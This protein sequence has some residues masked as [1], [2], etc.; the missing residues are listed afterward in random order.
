M[1]ISS[2]QLDYDSAERG[3][4]HTQL[5]E[6]NA[7]KA[8]KINELECRLAD[9]EDKLKTADSRGNSQCTYP[10]TVII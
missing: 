8:G 4:L 5:R 10:R 2:I 3:N 6:E 1:I 7:L 9:L